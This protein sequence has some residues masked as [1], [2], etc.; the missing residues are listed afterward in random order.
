VIGELMLD[1]NAVSALAK[2][3][4]S[5]LA[6]RLDEQAFCISV[7]TEAE[8]RFGLARRPVNANLRRIVEQFLNTTKVKP[9]NSDCAQR[10]A[11]LRAELEI[12]G[13]PLAPMDLLIATHALAEDCI[14]ISADRAFAQ[15][16]GL[17]LFDW[18]AIPAAEPADRVRAKLT[19]A[20]ITPGD[21]GAAVSHKRTSVRHAPPKARRAKKPKLK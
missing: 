5:P 1:T 10:Y 17:R 20:G 4:A 8:L 9:W 18:S 14:L 11:S 12:R 2:G 6:E 19:R 7:I 16:P 13:T 15:V 21:V 3:Q